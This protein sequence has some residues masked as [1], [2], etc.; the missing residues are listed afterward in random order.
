MATERKAGKGA[1]VRYDEKIGP[2]VA[3]P[4]QPKDLNSLIKKDH[5]EG[6]SQAIANSAKSQGLATGF[7]PNFSSFGESFGLGLLQGMG[8][9]SIDDA[10]IRIF[11]K[12]SARAAK[13]LD[14]TNKQINRLER[15]MQQ[16]RAQG[17]DPTSAQFKALEN[18]AERLR[19]SSGDLAKE[20]SR[21]KESIQK[22]RDTFNKASFA[23]SAFGGALNQLIPENNRYKRAI[24][25]GITS[26]ERAASIGATLPGPL[27]TFAAV[28]TATHGVL[29]FLE[30]RAFAAASQMPEL[31]D[32]AKK[33]AET[34]QKLTS[35]TQQFTQAQ[36]QLAEA[37]KNGVTDVDSLARLNVEVNKAITEIAKI[38]P[39]LAE[40]LKSANQ[41]EQQV[42]I[43]QVVEEQGRKK[44]EGERV[45]AI[46][47]TIIQDKSFGK[48]GFFGD[49]K[50]AGRQTFSFAKN[51]L[52]GSLDQKG[53]ESATKALANLDA[54]GSNASAVFDN[55]KESLGADAVEALREAHKKNANAINSV[56]ANLRNITKN[57]AEQRKA[58]RDLI[59]NNAGRIASIRLLKNLNQ[60]LID[61]EVEKVKALRQS[62]LANISFVED[63]RATATEIGNI[64]ATQKTQ[65]ERSVQDK[66]VSDSTKFFSSQLGKLQSTGGRANEVQSGIIS[67][68]QKTLASGN[69]SKIADIPRD[70]NK[71]LINNEKELSQ[72]SFV[73][74]TIDQTNKKAYN[75][76]RK[77]VDELALTNR[78]LKEVQ[79]L[80][81]N[82][83]RQ[84]AKQA[85]EMSRKLDILRE[86]KTD[87][88]QQGGIDTFVDRSKSRSD[89]RGLSRSISR[90]FG[91][92]SSETRARGS[93]QLFRNLQTL[94]GSENISQGSRSALRANA[95]AGLEKSI[96]KNLTRA[97]SRLQRRGAPQAVISDLRKQLNRSGEIAQRQ[98]DAELKT[99]QMPYDIEAIKN[100]TDPSN[101]TQAFVAALE[102]LDLKSV[103]GEYQSGLKS[104]IEQVAPAM[105]GY[106]GSIE[107]YTTTLSNLI[108]EMEATIGKPKDVKDVKP[109]GPPDEPLGD[110]IKNLPWTEI[111]TGLASALIQ[112]FI[113]RRAV[114]LPTA[115]QGYI[116]EAFSTEEAKAKSLGASSN[117]KAH[118]GK[119][120]I[121]GKPFVMNNQ[122]LE[123]PRFGGGRDSAVIP[124]YFTGNNLA[125][126]DSKKLQK[127][128]RAVGSEVKP[129][130]LK[131]TIENLSL[132]ALKNK[133]ISLEKL[134]EYTEVKKSVWEN[135]LPKGSINNN[136]MVTTNIKNVPTKMVV[137]RGGL[138]RIERA[139]KA[140]TAA[141]T[142]KAAAATAG[143]V[144]D[145]KMLKM[146]RDLRAQAE[147]VRQKQAQA[148]KPALVPT[149]DRVIKNFR[150]QVG[151]NQEAQKIKRN[152]GAI[153]KH[154]KDFSYKKEL[155]GRARMGR[156]L[157]DSMRGGLRAGGLL[158]VL[159]SAYAEKDA[160]FS[161]DLA[162]GGAAATRVA[163]TALFGA[164]GTGVGSFL[165]GP[166]G[167]IVLGTAGAKLGGWLGDMAGEKLFGLSK[168]D[169]DK[170]LA[171][172]RQ[173]IL[174]AAEAKKLK[175]KNK[176]IKKNKDNLKQ[177][178]VSALQEQI[179]TTPEGAEG[180]Y[181]HNFSESNF[182]KS[183]LA[184]FY[185]DGNFDDPE[186]LNKV[187]KHLNLLVSAGKKEKRILDGLTRRYGGD[188]G[189][190]RYKKRFGD[191]NPTEE[192]RDPWGFN[193]L[194][195]KELEEQERKIAGAASGYLPPNVAA[196]EEKM[197][198]SLGAGFGV[199]AHWG[200]GTING[201]SFVMNS[202]E[203]EIPNFGGGK[204]SAVIPHYAEGT[205]IDT[206]SMENSLS[207]T[208]ASLQE[209]IVVSERTA[210]A[211][212]TNASVS[213]EI[214][215]QMQ[216]LNA[217]FSQLASAVSQQQQQQKS[218]SEG[219]SKSAA[220][221]PGPEGKFAGFI[222]RTLS[223]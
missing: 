214:L 67:G 132:S 34:F 88:G 10:A 80:G 36:N 98:L 192:L 163:G 202:R 118:W 189:Y 144:D 169:S 156:A 68:I 195:D 124:M 149:N 70:I 170:F 16:M 24:G 97:I 139:A 38:N 120:T 205:K 20:A 31:L 52:F 165:G 63:A 129:E 27:G 162:L 173:D 155:V 113:L 61:S 96:R 11:Y 140:T 166:L 148:K 157:K 211:S 47:K 22:S 212:E 21:G 82:E 1:E 69:I 117:V 180:L 209:N 12:S 218:V 7:L 71:Q 185:E 167:A 125:K 33:S 122:E 138:N 89:Q 102:N 85:A 39:Q 15:S 179:P 190:A 181:K 2:Y 146:K 182:F 187:N 223:F 103:F 99:Q 44:A 206:S 93:I 221:I 136:G 197:A 200:K 28:T 74:S 19:L 137:T 199:K 133:H 49:P 115:A 130:K 147:A 160:L 95:A 143:V 196:T 112:A 191:F 152:A 123:I 58:A 51:Q 153:N 134:A 5:P 150:D 219:A 92:G 75:D 60:S 222:P 87:L 184:D 42:I 208:T 213:V 54:D 46:D 29:T 164:I 107:G 78:T 26:L 73:L 66:F 41:K 25:D 84:S 8:G 141:Q 59:K 183:A 217:G 13:A 109:E 56:L 216:Q 193:M 23:I 35:S 4:S 40:R 6:L 154:L 3:Q 201:K 174:K 131:G 198:R 83:L 18:E 45:A 94:I 119:G 172:R 108:G 72:A 77:T 194:S 53:I 145:E 116:P 100:N 105:G 30:E 204:D 90:A 55:L 178:I 135:H 50:D 175:E 104:A 62:Q 110:K 114:K 158:G 79:N 176:Q 101:T 161:G 86:I 111:G 106:T 177:N 128:L 64:F 188:E 17:V 121:K 126:L 14:A 76:Q 168:E 127:I 9:G 57:Y 91:S 220:Q 203:T 215:S 186:N 171:G 207:Q 142:P 151:I 210:A 159:G 37:L 48:T 43:N 65:D 32:Q 81:L